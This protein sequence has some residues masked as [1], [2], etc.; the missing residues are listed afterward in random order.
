MW[1]KITA[2]TMICILCAFFSF[3]ITDAAEVSGTKQDV[4]DYKQISALI[5]DTWDDDYFEK[6]VITP[7]TDTMEK[8]GEQEQVSDTFDVSSSKAKSITK[9]EE[10][11]DNY[12]DK[13]DGVYEVKENTDGDLEVTAPYQTK[14]LIVESDQV[15]DTCGASEVYVNEMDHE[16][17]LQYDSEE[18]TEEAFQQ[19]SRTYS[20]CYPD[21]VVSIEDS[22]MG[23]PLSQGGENGQGTYSWGSDYMGLNELK[24][25]A[26]SSGYTRRVTVAVVDT[27]I[28][29]SNVLFAGRKVS[30]QSYNF[31]GN[32]H[33][34]Q[35]TFGHGTHVSGIIADA[36]PANVELL[37]L[38]V[39]NNEGKSSL[40]TIKTALQYAVSKNADVVNLSMGMPAYMIIL[41]RQL[42][43]HII[44]GFLFAALPVME[45]VE[46]K[47]WMFV[48]V[49]QPAIVKRSLFQQLI[50]AG[51]LPII[52]IVEVPLILRLREAVL[53][54]LTIKETLRQCQ[55]HLWQ[56]LILQ[57]RLLI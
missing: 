46:V 42:I 19:L 20:S 28:D 54:A 36:T 18:K 39:S 15:K 30:S 9:S 40:L 53:S 25:Q 22:T 17:I 13:Q 31:F 51:S 45:K 47:V 32:N 44:E 4:T 35:D 3:R 16:T 34:V 5:S 37:V 33:N 8:D 55:E 7:G 21:K 6:M 24:K 11:L 38:R 26:A 12:L 23:L 14:R 50:Q 1:K 10:V 2:V 57:R 49:I 56:H 52:P 41:I 48:I 27:G 43:R 29:T